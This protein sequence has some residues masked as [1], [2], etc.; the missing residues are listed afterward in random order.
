LP[1]LFEGDG[2]DA[3]LQKRV[4]ELRTLRKEIQES[5]LPFKESSLAEQ[6]N[7]AGGLF[8]PP[9]L[10]HVNLPSRQGEDKG[11]DESR[12]PRAPKP[13]DFTG[14][15]T[16]LNEEAARA[17]LDLQRRVVEIIGN[18]KTL[19]I[20]ALQ[21][22]AAHR[23]RNLR[24]AK[25]NLDAIASVERIA[26]L[27]TLQ[28]QL[29]Q[30]TRTSELHQRQLQE[31]EESS[32]RRIELIEQ[33]T[34]LRTNQ[35]VNQ[36]Q[37]NRTEQDLADSQG[38][39]LQRI[40]MLREQEGSIIQRIAAIETEQRQRQIA[41]AQDLMVLV[42][43]RYDEEEQR[44]QQLKTLRDQTKDPL[45]AGVQDAQIEILTDNL[46]EIDQRY[47][48]IKNRVAEWDAEQLRADGDIRQS[49]AR[50]NED[51]R[52]LQAPVSTRVFEQLGR[53]A[54]QSADRM[55]SA[56]VNA[57]DRSADALAEFVTTGKFSLDAFRQI[58]LDLLRDINREVVGGL[59]RRAI[60]IQ[61]PQG[62]SSL[63]ASVIDRISGSQPQ[64][65]TFKPSTLAEQIGLANAPF[66]GSLPKTPL[67]SI[68][69]PFIPETNQQIDQLGTTILQISDLAE[70]GLTTISSLGTSTLSHLSQIGSQS[71]S[72]LGQVASQALSLIAGS[73]GAGSGGGG[74]LASLFSLFG[75]SGGGAGA[76]TFSSFS[77]AD[78]NVPF[79]HEG[80]LPGTQL[81]THPVS[82]LV[83]ARAKRLHD[84]LMPDEFPA[85]LQ[86]GEAVL[87]RRQVAAMNEAP[88]A[89]VQLDRQGKQ[90]S[91]RPINLH[92]HGVQDMASFR[93][94]ESPLQAF[95]ARSLKKADQRNN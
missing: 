93:R 40:I 24:E 52:R 36:L 51:L 88:G 16:R 90:P 32:R 55:A 56:W 19:E 63:L 84:G 58:E 12:G 21:E 11:K 6:F 27:E 37:G 44:L 22:V 33:E 46:Q 28:A 76:T 38:A 64:T 41:E 7:L 31:A 23:A 61:S 25:G 5:L 69:P 79:F 70:T 94:S 1:R 95:A 34:R 60:G 42:R 17:Q 15:I 30:A 92:F 67:P 75:S 87:S 81:V 57:F 91:T 49:L 59:L 18:T 65:P 68:T 86:A 39:P 47:Q 73:S 10:R 71:F 80:N 29:D 8:L 77:F 54:N 83:F 2:S 72:L 66:L 43:Q 74:F 35:Q 82:P 78:L 48:S 3:A 9:S 20:A 89:M 13:Q 4:A 45:I 53:E 14:I 62:P 26:H 50:I 85:I